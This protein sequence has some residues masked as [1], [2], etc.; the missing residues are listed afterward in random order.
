[1][2]IDMR[3]APDELTALVAALSHR[4]VMPGRARQLRAH[5]RVGGGD[6]GRRARRRAQRTG[7][8]HQ[9]PPARC[10]RRVRAPDPTACRTPTRRSSSRTAPASPARR[11]PRFESSTRSRSA[12]DSTVCRSPIELAASQ[13]RVMDADEI[14]A[15]LRTSWRSVGRPRRSSP[16]QRTL[17][18][19]VQWSY[20][21]LAPSAQSTS[22]GS[23]C[24][25]RRSRSPRRRPCAPRVQ[26]HRRTVLDRPDDPD[27]P[28]AARPRPV[29]LGLVAVP[30]AGDAA[31]VRRRAAG[32]VGRGS[33]SARRAHAEFF[34]ALADEGGADLYGPQE[35]TWR[36]S[37]RARGAEPARRAGVG[38]RPRPRVRAR[39]SPSPSG[40]T[41]M[42]G[43]VSGRASSTS[44]ICSVLDVAVPGRR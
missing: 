5:R 15:R 29:A 36:A 18:E 23:A 42:P 25:P 17:G 26:T 13:L 2:A 41:G 38:C 28:L 37:A 7:A 14:I 16:R 8:R 20:E 33:E 1:M 32:G 21:L 39:G 35:R 12:A 40:R 30:T 27:R 3:H 22:P 43:G 19:M 10:R 44:T 9:P 6:D 31:A 24:S 11:R 34:L 4:A